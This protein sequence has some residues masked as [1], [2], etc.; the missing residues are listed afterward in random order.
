VR[1][2][3]G[4]RHTCGLLLLPVPQGLYPLQQFG[5][6]KVAVI[7]ARHTST[8]TRVAATLASAACL[9][10]GGCATV[11]PGPISVRELAEAQTFPYYPV[12][13]TGP[14]F[15]S[16]PLAAAD[17]R[18][19]YN[20]TVGDSVYYSDC[21]SGKKPPL[22]GGGCQLPLQVTTLVYTRHANA[23]LGPQRNVL[24]RGVPATIYDDG[25]S[26]ELYSGRLAIDVH[27]DSLPDALRA[28]RELRP[29]N[30]PGSAAGPLPPPVFCP[31][32]TESRPARVRAALARLPDRACQRA[33]AALTATRALFGKQ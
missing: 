18:E 1:Y 29:I 23:A 16:Y 32:L 14:R 5:N 10:A 30:A 20:S 17:G 9:L 12:Y 28:V 13:W 8:Q 6:P 27:S 3:T 22:G 31:G 4:P 2:P 15:G 21:L 24:L 25:Q 26:I 7:I 33:A 11:H 19:S